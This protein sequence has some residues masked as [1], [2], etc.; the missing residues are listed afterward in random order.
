MHP[1]HRFWC[2]TVSISSRNYKKW[3][4]SH[5]GRP[6]SLW[7]HYVVR[8]VEHV[9]GISDFLK[10]ASRTPFL[11]SNSK[12]YI[13]ALQKN[14][15]GVILDGCC[16]SDVIPE[17]ILWI[18]YVVFLTSLKIHLEHRFWCQT[19]SISSWHYEN[20]VLVSFQSTGVAL[21]SLRSSYCGVEHVGGISDFLKNASITPFLVSNN[22]YFIS[23]VQ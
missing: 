21:T 5:S 14:V 11:V 2:Q 22:I 17:F 6:V 10:N 7:R 1:E 4:W 9:G 12:Y 19:T 20:M 8:T 13:L 23:A 3:F 16:L 15:F 18:M